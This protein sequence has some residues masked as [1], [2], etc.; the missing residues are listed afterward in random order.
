MKD[1]ELMLGDLVHLSTTLGDDTDARVKSITPGL[2]GL[3]YLDGSGDEDVWVCD[4]L[5]P[6]ILTGSMLLWNGFDESYDQDYD[7]NRYYINYGDKTR[8]MM[9]SSPK[10]G[11]YRFKTWGKEV[12]IKYVHEFQHILRI[13]GENELADNFELDY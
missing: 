8:F 2:V 4:C 3:E 12:R 1:T 5:N 13:V 9:S 6:I 11:F 10:E 7:N